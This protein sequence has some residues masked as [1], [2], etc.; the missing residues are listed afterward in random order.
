M[1]TGTCPVK[2]SALSRCVTSVTSQDTFG[3]FAPSS[4]LRVSRWTSVY[5]RT[6]FLVAAPAP[7]SLPMDFILRVPYA[8]CLFSP[9]ATYSRVS[10]YD[11]DVPLIH[12]LHRTCFASLQRPHHLI[13]TLSFYTLRVATFSFVLISNHCVQPVPP[14]IHHPIDLQHLFRHF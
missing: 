7:F 3:P 4:P 11:T 14:T 6:H 5:Y 2:L 1:H 9:I 13:I 8:H 10:D 12:W